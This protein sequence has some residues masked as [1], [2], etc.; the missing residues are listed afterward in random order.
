MWDFCGMS[1]SG[2]GLNRAIS[3]IA[4]LREQFWKDVRV[5]GK[6]EEFNVSLENAGRVAD[7]LEFAE[8]LCYDALNREESCGAHFREEYQTP[9]GEARRNDEAFSYIAAWQFN[10]VGE[11]PLLHT[12]PLL[13]EHAALATRSYK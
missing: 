3:L 8:I 12:E 2:Q 4:E 10:G 1:R 7:F 11:K 13:F 5:T 6:N 9:E